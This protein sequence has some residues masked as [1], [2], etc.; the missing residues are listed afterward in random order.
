LFGEADRI[1]IEEAARAGT[2]RIV[3][4]SSVA[5]DDTIIGHKHRDTE[6]SLRASGLPW[7]ILRAGAFM[8]NALEWIPSIKAKGMVATPIADALLASISPGDLAK[9]AAIAL[10]TSVHDGRVYELTGTELLSTR[11]QVGI[12]ARVLC[13]TIECV[14]I[15]IE[16]MA[17]S[18]DAT[19]HTAVAGRCGQP[20]DEPHS[21]GTSGLAHVSVRGIDWNTAGYL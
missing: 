20:T 13:R 14:E 8:S 6:D 12:L 19:R 17:D 18:N 15:S 9:A 21:R 11:D 3:M 2:E 5:P 1:L 4:I 16:A 7:T 10:T